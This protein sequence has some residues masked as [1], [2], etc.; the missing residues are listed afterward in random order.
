MHSQLEELQAMS[1]TPS[2]TEEHRQERSMQLAARHRVQPA[3][4]G[5]HAQVQRALEQRARTE[6]LAR[7]SRALQLKLAL[8]QKGL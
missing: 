7:S 3:V 2:V 6:Q 5:E 4:T 8:P 1:A